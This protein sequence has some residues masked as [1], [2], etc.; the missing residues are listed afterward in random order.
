MSKVNRRRFTIE[1]FADRLTAKCR[2][3]GS[4]VCVGIDPV[5]ERLPSS[6]RAK[7]RD[8]DDSPH[9]GIRLAAIHEYCS[10]VLHA[11]APHAACI[12]L[13]SACFERYL[14]PGVQLYHTLVNEAAN[15]GLL[16]IG[17]AKRGDIGISAEHYAAGCLTDAPFADLDEPAAPDALTIN[18]YLGDDS[19]QPFIDAARAHQKGLFALV[20]T[21][22]PGGD[23][24]QTLQLA[25]GRSVADA[26]AALIARLGD[27]PGNIGQSGF[28]LLG[29][30]V[31]ATKAEDARR[32]RELMPHQIF[33]VPG[34]GAQGGK[35]DD[36]RAC[37]NADG[38]GAIITASRS[39]LYAYEKPATDDW[40]G[41]IEA[42]AV[43]MKAEISALL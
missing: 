23:A 31:G 37:F 13:Q 19:I 2:E 6:V 33:L 36:V 22:N 1:S 27:Q 14:W 25:D 7:H 35:A 43:K 21:S 32:L 5:W 26:V 38:H 9:A 24:I 15:L 10:G 17:D 39:V 29:A 16:I 8:A 30:V 12:K 41:A 3:K 42:A 18:A 34:F 28:S 4:P 40:M 11:V 20:R